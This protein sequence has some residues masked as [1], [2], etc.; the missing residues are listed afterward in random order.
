MKAADFRNRD[1][2]S[3]G[4]VR[5]G[6][7]LWRVLRQPQVCSSPMIVPAVDSEDA[8]EMRRIEHDHMIQAF[9]TN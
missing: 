4:R 6:S 1:D 8:S 2:W 5:G 9:A 7:G 3:R